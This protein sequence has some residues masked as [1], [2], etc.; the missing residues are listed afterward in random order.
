MTTTQQKIEKIKANG[1]E[2]DFGTVFNDAFENYKKIALYAGSII[3][4]F[5]V[6]MGMLLAGGFVLTFGMAAL[7]QMANPE[8][9][10]L[11]NL[12]G[13]NL[14]IYLVSLIL[15]SLLIGPFF[16]GFIKMAQAADRDEAFNSSAIFTYYKA[17]YFIKIITATLIISISNAVLSTLFNYI[18][19][20]LLGSFSS[21]C[22]SIFTLLTIPLIIFGNLNPTE[23]ITASI[24][25]VLKNPFVIVALIVTAFIGSLVGFVGCCIGVFF[26]IPIMYALNYALYKAII[27]FDDPEQPEE[28]P[29]V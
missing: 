6:L 28:L 3:L 13:I 4:V 29:L 16:A 11:E 25:L 2:L 20:P 12:V 18:N 19:L 27:G 1:L 23:A 21:I 8:N 9:L 14:F 15:I 26:T 5:S 24:Q 17:P 7:A 22:I 10:A